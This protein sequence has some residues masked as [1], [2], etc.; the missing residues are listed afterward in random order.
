MHKYYSIH[1]KKKKNLLML[2]LICIKTDAKYRK[3]NVQYFKYDGKFLGIL[4]FY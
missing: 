4:T 2:L 3:I 1:Q